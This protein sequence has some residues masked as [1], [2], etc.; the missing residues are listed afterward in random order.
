[1]WEKVGEVVS[2][3]MASWQDGVFLVEVEDASEEEVVEEE[4]L[5]LEPVVE[6]CSV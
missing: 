2:C 5:V 6:A 3:C 4:E 1:M